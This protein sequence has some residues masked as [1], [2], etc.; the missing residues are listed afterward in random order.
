MGIRVKH[1]PPP[2]MQVLRRRVALP[3]THRRVPLC[4]VRALPPPKC[5]AAVVEAAAASTT[6]TH[7]LPAYVETYVALV[8]GGAGPSHAP[9]SA[10]CVQTMIVP[11]L[12]EQLR[13]LTEL[14]SL[15]AHVD[16][17]G[18]ERVLFQLI[19]AHD[20][21]RIAELVDALRMMEAAMSVVSEVVRAVGTDVRALDVV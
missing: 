18:L 16:P 1:T 13:V 2:R 15:M 9:A 17:H 3:S 4:A 8:C 10:A 6:V 14:R 12:D 19:L 7:I 11:P 20:E 5:A 21:T